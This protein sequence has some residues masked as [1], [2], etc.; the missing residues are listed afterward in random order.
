MS[1]C[2]VK[3]GFVALRDC[4]SDATGTC[5]DCSRG[6]CAEH[7]KIMSADIVCVECFSKRQMTQAEAKAKEENHGKFSLGSGTDGGKAKAKGFVSRPQDD[8]WNDRSWAYGYRTRYYSYYDYNPFFYG[9]YH[10]YYDSY[11]VRSFDEYDE[12][13]SPDDET[14]AGFYD[15]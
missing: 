13:T 15:S 14:A 12:G 11:D 4:G 2:A 1:K 10:S 8:D 6:I 7:T 9:H 3:R 5:A